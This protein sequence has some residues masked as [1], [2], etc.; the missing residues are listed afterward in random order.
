MRSFVDAINRH[1]VEAIVAQTSGTHRFID[2][3]GVALGGGRPKIAEAW[4]RYF[5]IVPDYTI[6]VSEI[7]VIDG[8]DIIML[9]IACGTYSGVFGGTPGFWRTPAVWRASVAA[10][11]IDRWQIFADNEPLRKLMRGAR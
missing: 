11:K 5:R 8:G 7:G 10:G 9:G 1:D 4:K 3:L 2:S 6:E